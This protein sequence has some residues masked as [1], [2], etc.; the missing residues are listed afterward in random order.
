MI[1]RIRGA[2]SARHQAVCEAEAL[3]WRLGDRAEAV[4]L[5]CA[6]S[7][8]GRVKVHFQRVARIAR[9]RNDLIEGRDTTTGYDGNARWLSRAGALLL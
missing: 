9:R 4:A 5:S 7:A 2:L 8:D 6:A 3:V 1:S